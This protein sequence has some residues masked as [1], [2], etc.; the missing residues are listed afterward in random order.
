MNIPIPINFIVKAMKW[1]WG[2]I[3]KLMLQKI[4]LQSHRKWNARH[5][6]GARW[7]TLGEHLEYSVR[8]A[9]PTDPKPQVSRFAIRSTGSRLETVDLY[10]E[11]S[12]AGLRYQDKISAYDVDRSPMIWNL[13]NIPVQRFLDWPDEGIHFSVEEYQLLN[14]VVKPWNNQQSFPRNSVRAYLTHNWIMNDD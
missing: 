11:A 5:R 10:F 6:L 8:L 9:Q 13:N 7:Q 1:T 3:T 12:G 2:C 4:Y 14:C